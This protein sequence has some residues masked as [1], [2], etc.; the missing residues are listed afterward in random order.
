MLDRIG[1]RWRRHHRDG[2]L[3]GKVCRHKPILHGLQLAEARHKEDDGMLSGLQEATGL[4]EGAERN[5][6]VAC[7]GYVGGEGSAM[8]LAKS[9]A[10]PRPQAHPREGA[11]DGLR[12]PLFTRWTLNRK[13]KWHQPN[14]TCLDHVPA[15]AAEDVAV[16]WG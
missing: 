5:M 1:P 2:D 16:D 6:K 8:V 10:I 7:R 14:T 15:W 3:R 12:G 13:Q 9:A 11:K 4:P